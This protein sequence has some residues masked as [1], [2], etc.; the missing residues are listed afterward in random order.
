M[1]GPP[2][3]QTTLMHTHVYLHGDTEARYL[4]D[5]VSYKCI[6]IKPNVHRS[7]ALS[8]SMVT[9][10]PSTVVNEGCI[11]I[12]IQS[13]IYVMISSQPTHTLKKLQCIQT[14]WRGLKS[15]T[16]IC[17]KYTLCDSPP[18]SPFL[19]SPFIDRFFV[20]LYSCLFSHLFVEFSLAVSHFGAH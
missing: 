6:S 16:Y 12:W 11:Q 7:R 19:G 2:L 9:L 5:L 15:F 17:T 1:E 8:I 13:K 14:Q 18:S 20:F 4:E 3:L 10:E